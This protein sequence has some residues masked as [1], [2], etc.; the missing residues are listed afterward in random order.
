MSPRK[1]A[2]SPRR[3]HVQ[4]GH[5]LFLPFGW[6]KVLNSLEGVRAS[7]QAQKAMSVC[8]DSKYHNMIHRNQKLFDTGQGT[9]EV[10]S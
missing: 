3:A 9:L 4:L 2:I 1:E 6:L 10:R 7:D 5:A 8:L